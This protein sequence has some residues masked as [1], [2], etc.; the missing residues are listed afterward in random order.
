MCRTINNECLVKPNESWPK[1][2]KRTTN[3]K[4]IVDTSKANLVIEIFVYEVDIIMLFINFY[5][6]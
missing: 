1:L 2:I 4:F 3:N 5:K 6:K